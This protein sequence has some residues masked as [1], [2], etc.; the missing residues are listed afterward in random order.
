M[1]KAPKDNHANVLPKHHENNGC[2][3]KQRKNETVPP[4]CRDATKIQTI[5]LKAK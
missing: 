5:A 4:K 2:H 1:T 3:L